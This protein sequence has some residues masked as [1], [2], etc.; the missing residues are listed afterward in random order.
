MANM[1][2]ADWTSKKKKKLPSY[3]AFYNTVDQTRYVPLNAAYITLHAA[4]ELCL[5]L[6]QV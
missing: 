1:Q 2:N 5:E 3:S 6:R 4:A